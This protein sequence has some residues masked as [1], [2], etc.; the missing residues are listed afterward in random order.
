ME[1]RNKTNDELFLLYDADLILRNKNARELKDC[2]RLLGLF[3]RELDNFPPSI[4]L[5]KRFLAQYADRKPTTLAKYASRIKMFMKWYGEPMDDFKVKI[6]KSLPPITQDTDIEALFEAIEH[7]RSH[8]DIIVRDILMVETALKTGLRRAELSNLEV[9]D[10][11]TDFIV[12]RHG[13]GDKDRVVPLLPA[14]ATRLSSF[15]RDMSPNNKVFNLKPGT[16]SNKIKRFAKKAGIDFHAHMTRHKFACDLL[17]RGANLRQVQE[18]LGH[19]RIDTTQVYLSVTDDGLREAIN[20]LDD[21][22]T[23]SKKP[24]YKGEYAVMPN[25][26]E[27]EMPDGTILEVDK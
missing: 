3:H 26:Y 13:K 11:H 14:L 27:V 15:T 5:A 18:L 1:L 21:R 4:D 9:R 8:K 17:N 24:R 23:K 25:N 10:C 12:I 7:K 6:P 2:R 20:R 22:P 19:S 16:I